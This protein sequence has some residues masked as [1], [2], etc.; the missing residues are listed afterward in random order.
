MPLLLGLQLTFQKLAKGTH[1]PPFLSLSR[2]NLGIEFLS[3]EELKIMTIEFEF[4]IL[5]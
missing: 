3:N 5:D 1:P 4:L 2:R